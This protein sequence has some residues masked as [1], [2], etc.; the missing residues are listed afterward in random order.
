MAKIAIYPGTFDPVTNGHID[1]IER[2]LKIFNK[3]IVAVIKRSDKNTLFD[4]EERIFLLK[5]STEHLENITIDAFDELLVY[6]A[7]KKNA[8]AVI[9]GVRAISDFDYEFQMALMNRKMVK[10]IETVFMIPNEIYSYLSSSV[11]KEVAQY[12]GNIEA[13][14]P[15]FVNEKLRK[16]FNIKN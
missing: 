11:V 8:Q 9:R 10:D 2:G 3:I 16:K 13:L 7:R 5:K 4:I 15:K 14:V 12:G 6:Y 1:I